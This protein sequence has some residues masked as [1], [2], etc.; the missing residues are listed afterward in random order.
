M[1]A[2][3]AS[4]HGLVSPLSLSLLVPPSLDFPHHQPEFCAEI[5]YVF[6]KLTVCQPVFET[7]MRHSHTQ[8]DKLLL[9]P[10]KN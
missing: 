1:V 4:T 3:F 5:Y 2:T 9:G 6:P 8:T 10:G 7:V